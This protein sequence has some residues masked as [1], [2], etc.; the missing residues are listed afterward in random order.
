MSIR[1]GPSAT[2]VAVDQ[3]TDELTG[4]FTHDIPLPVSQ[5]NR[6]QMLAA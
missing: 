6:S 5:F 2:P 3:P 4:A 1:V